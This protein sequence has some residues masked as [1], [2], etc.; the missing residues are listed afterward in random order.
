MR[1][2]PAACGTVWCPASGECR[3]Q[4]GSSEGFLVA[5]RIS[6]DQTIF[7]DA[8]MCAPCSCERND[9]PSR[10]RGRGRSMAHAPSGKGFQGQPIVN[11]VDSCSWK[12]YQKS[13]EEELSYAAH[14]VAQTDQFEIPRSQ[15]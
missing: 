11:A 4:L 9:P 1:S 5:F 3:G 2:T 15:T 7:Q 10:T 6:A 13:F 8:R 12:P 14:L